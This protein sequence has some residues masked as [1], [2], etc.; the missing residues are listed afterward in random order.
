MRMSHPHFWQVAELAP[1]FLTTL[2]L[3][4]GRVEVGGSLYIGNYTKQ[5]RNNSG[6][7]W[8]HRMLYL[9][10]FLQ[11]SSVDNIIVY[12]EDCF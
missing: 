12:S 11:S 3:T 9:K 6:H 8:Y 7:D 5:A 10:W 2:S 4:E 1:R